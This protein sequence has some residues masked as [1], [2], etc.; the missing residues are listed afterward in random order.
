MQ[1]QTEITQKVENIEEA[2]RQLGVTETT[3]SDAEKESLDRDGYLLVPGVIGPEW[4]AR[5]RQVYED[6]MEKEGEKAGL[7]VHQEA[8]TRRLADLINKDEAFDGIYTHPK[9]LA[10]VYHILKREFKL[11]SLNARDA[12]PG[13][14]H[15]GFHA[16]WGEPIDG[17]HFSVVNSIW[18]LDDFTEENGATRVVPGAHRLPGGV[19][20][21]MEDP[22]APHPN[23]RLIIAPAGSVGIFNAHLW[24]GGTTNRSQS[25]RR[26][27]HCFFSSRELPQQLNQKEYIR[28]KTFDR[29]SPAARYILDVE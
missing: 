23:Q 21:Y 29:I 27:Y 14:G 17:V 13:F 28:K 18:L 2:L 6:L 8:G 15:Q 11:S 5:L 10:A 25:T 12:L 16:D 20:D 9:L 26:A 7:E 3:L 1:V 22:A 4:L 24:H 19:K